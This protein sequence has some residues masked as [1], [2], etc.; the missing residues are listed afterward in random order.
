MIPTKPLYELGTSSICS[1]T[2]T[3]N[4]ERLYQLRPGDVFTVSIGSFASS[5]ILW[6]GG[7]F[8]IVAVKKVRLYWNVRLFNL[9]FS[10]PQP[11]SVWMITFRFQEKQEVP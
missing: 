1:T 10:I 8:Q 3:S 6:N 2:K 9:R 4:S 11:R 5:P 7:K